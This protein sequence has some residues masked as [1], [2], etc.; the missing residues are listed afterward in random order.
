[1]DRFQMATTA[2][3]AVELTYEISTLV[4]TGL[5]RKALALAISLCEQGAD[6]AAVTAVIRECQKHHT[7][8]ANAG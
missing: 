2:K 3:E 4:E 1:M 7:F 5:D 8:A 6:P